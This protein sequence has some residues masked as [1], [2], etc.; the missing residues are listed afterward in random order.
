MTLPGPGGPGAPGP[1][2][3]RGPHAARR[4]PAG[5]DT[6]ALGRLPDSLGRRDRIGLS[7]SCKFANSGKWRMRYN[8]PAHRTSPVDRPY[9]KIARG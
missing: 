5:A 7:D 6:A 4:G 9:R 8:G 1:F 2:P 3:D